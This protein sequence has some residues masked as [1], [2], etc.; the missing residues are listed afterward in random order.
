VNHFGVLR[1]RKRKYTIP[2]AVGAKDG[3]L[4]SLRAE[5]KTISLFSNRVVEVP[6]RTLLAGQV[7]TTYGTDF[8][9]LPESAALPSIS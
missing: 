6:F 3:L 8:V 5:L 4:R 2:S 9:G 1:K 7:Q